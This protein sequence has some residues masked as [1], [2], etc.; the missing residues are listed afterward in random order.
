MERG[1]LQNK[2]RGRERW[3]AFGPPG[4]NKIETNYLKFTAGRERDL[5]K[6]PEILYNNTKS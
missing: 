5:D 2:L 4:W 1:D 3:T 6:L